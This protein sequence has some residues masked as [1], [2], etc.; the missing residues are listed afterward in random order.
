MV[1]L[2]PALDA[3][4]C[5]RGTWGGRRQP[6]IETASQGVTAH[7]CARFQAGLGAVAKM[8]EDQPGERSAVHRRRGDGAGA[9]SRSAT[10]SGSIERHDW[11]FV[12]ERFVMGRPQL[13]CRICWA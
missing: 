1:L 10:T 6:L 11:C 13:L 3:L 12:V 8:G 5:R 9:S 2:G 4:V 7:V